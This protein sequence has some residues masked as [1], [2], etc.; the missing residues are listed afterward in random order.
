MADSNPKS[1]EH[2]EIY[3]RIADRCDTTYEHVYELAHGKHSHNHEDDDILEM[4]H[5]EHIISLHKAKRKRHRHGKK[6]HPLR[7]ALFNLLYI[8]FFLAFIY[9]IFTH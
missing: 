8:L 4:L 1:S 6:K 3:Q 7:R 9:Y 2:A 5:D